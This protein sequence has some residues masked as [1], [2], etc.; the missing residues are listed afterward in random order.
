MRNQILDDLMDAKVIS[1]YKYEKV[2]DQ[3]Q[4]YKDIRTSQKLT[5]IFPNNTSIA[6]TTWCSGCLENTRFSIENK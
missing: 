4:P 6:L 2:H 3:C 5:F 1:S